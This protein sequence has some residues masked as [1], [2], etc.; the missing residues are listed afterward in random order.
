MKPALQSK[1]SSN[2]SLTE[3]E[4]SIG[5]LLNEPVVQIE[6]EQGRN[7]SLITDHTSYAVLQQTL[8][9]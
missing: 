4:K 1:R 7:P 2:L 8:I 3:L 5:N 9:F 6:I